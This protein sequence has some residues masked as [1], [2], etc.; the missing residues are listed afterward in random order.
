MMMEVMPDRLLE[1][2]AV[3]SPHWDCDIASKT[4]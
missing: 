2:A 3:G 4:P 1:L